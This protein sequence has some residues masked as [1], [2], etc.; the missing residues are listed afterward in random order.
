LEDRRK[1]LLDQQPFDYK[2]IKDNKIQIFFNGRLIKILHGS[3]YRKFKKIEVARDTFKIQL[4]LAKET[5]QFKHGNERHH[6]KK[7]SM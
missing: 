6:S 4:F 3:A 7:D 5:G 1:V 2:E